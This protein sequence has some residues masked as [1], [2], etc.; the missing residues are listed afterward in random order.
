[1]SSIDPTAQRAAAGVLRRLALSEEA[2]AFVLAT[3]PLYSA[4]LRAA[5]RYIAGERLPEALDHAR[6]VNALGHAVTFDYMG[7]STR[8]A[9]MADAATD[10]FVAAAREV[11]ALGLDATLSLDLS[12]IGLV[13]DESLCFENARRIAD[14]MRGDSGGTSREIIISAEGTDRTDAVLA[15]YQ[16]LSEVGAPYGITLQAFLFRTPQDLERVI[17]LPGKVRVVK[18]A[19][20]APASVARRRG[21]ELDAAYVQLVSR[22]SERNHSFSAATHDAALLPV[23]RPFLSA[24]TGEFEMLKGIGESDLLSLNRAGFRTRQYL[25]Y[26]TEWFLYLCNRLAEYPPDVFSAIAAAGSDPI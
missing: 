7:E 24:G 8:D 3:P 2:K 10:E 25:P 23:L 16:R 15:M 17:E 4:L 19:F 11:A 14:A 12:H 5:Q 22:L 21:P 13:I 6:R 18:G 26:G 1:M 20:D 9:A